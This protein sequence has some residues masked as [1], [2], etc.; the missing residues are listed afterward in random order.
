MISITIFLYIFLSFLCICAEQ[1]KPTVSLKFLHQINIPINSTNISFPLLAYIGK[2]EFISYIS[3]HSH[4][5]EF[6]EL[7]SLKKQSISFQSKQNFPY[8][9]FPVSKDSIILCYQIEGEW[10]KFPSLMDKTGNIIKEYSQIKQV[11]EDGK[12]LFYPH[13]M[14]TYISAEYLYATINL[15]DYP[16]NRDYFSVPHKFISKTNLINGETTFAPIQYPQ[17]YQGHLWRENLEWCLGKNGEIVYSFP[18][19]SF[20]VI[21][22]TLIST[23]LYKANSIRIDTIK[24]LASWEDLEVKISYMRNTPFYKEVIYDKYR[25]LYYRIAKYA[26]ADKDKAKYSLIVLN[27]AFTKLGEVDFPFDMVNDKRSV[28]LISKEGIYFRYL[29]VPNN[30]L[31]FKVYQVLV[32]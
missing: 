18:A 11:A 31:S 24:P 21:Q 7:P 30:Q 4:S 10:G 25:N 1:Q 32:D 15:F 22:D 28:P 29:D 12:I 19:S 17:S 2:Q 9:H 14:P 20:L 16:R 8:S 5:L 6:V 13:L 3:Y 26:N 23:K 27:D